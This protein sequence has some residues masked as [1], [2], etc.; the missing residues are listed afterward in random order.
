MGPLAP[1]ARIRGCVSHA[2]R[3]VA[4]IILEYSLVI[5]STSY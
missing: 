3:W 5:L 1:K 4:L 2:S